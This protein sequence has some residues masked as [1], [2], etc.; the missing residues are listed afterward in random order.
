MFR[1]IER[2]HPLPPL[3]DRFGVR[4]PSR[5]LRDLATV[6][7]H[8]PSGERF[9]MD[10]STAGFFRPDLSL[11]AYAG[12]VPKDG[13]SPILHFFDR[14]GGGHNFRG[15]ITRRTSRDYRGG[16]LTYDEHDGTDLVCPPGTPLA[17]AAP[18]VVVATRENFL[19]GGLT[20]CVDHGGGVVTQYTHL[21]AMVAEVGQPLARGETVGLSGAAGLDMISGFP[22]V[23][24]HVHFMVWIDGRPVDPFVA[25][26]E[27]EP[28]RPGTWLHGNSPETARGPLAGDPPPPSLSDIAIDRRALDAVIERCASPDIRAEI[29]RAP[30]DAARVAICEDSFHHDRSAWPDEARHSALRPPGDAASVKL[31]LPLP[32][33][34]YRGIRILDAPWTRPPR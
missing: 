16:R 15:A 30:S 29:E 26:G 17:S 7:S 5:V 1:P 20:A 11:P 33:A 32:A 28:A 19:R 21:S 10:L 23:A 8:L 6:L 3:A 14:V 31:T 9:V 27:D 2:T 25:P 18:G 4:G 34:I 12:L 24:P 22:W 13:L